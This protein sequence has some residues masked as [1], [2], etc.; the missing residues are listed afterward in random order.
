MQQKISRFKLRRVIE[1]CSGKIQVPE[2]DYTFSLK[3]YL[4]YGKVII[5]VYAT[6]GKLLFNLNQ[7]GYTLTFE[8]IKTVKYIRE[9][10]AVKKFTEYR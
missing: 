4:K 1:V 8:L 9:T 10:D 7:R 2:K 5:Y 6:A 3:L